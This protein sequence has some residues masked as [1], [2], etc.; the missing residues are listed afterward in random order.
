MKYLKSSI[1]FLV[2]LLSPV[3][4]LKSQD[5]WEQL[6]FPDSTAI[7][8]IAVND[9]GNIFVGA[10]NDGVSGGLYRSI[11][12]AQTW[13][14]VLDLGEFSVQS[15]AI[16]ENGY[17][18]IGRTG[19]Y[20]FMVS[21]DDGENWDALEL[22]SNGNVVSIQCIGIDTVFAGLAVSNGA[23]LLRSSD[24]GQS[25]DSV[26]TTIGHP[27]EYVSDIAVSSAGE[28]YISL[29]CFFSNMGGIYRSENG[30]DTWEYAGLINHQVYSVEFNSNDDLFIGVWSDFIYATGGLYTIYNGSDTVEELLF[31]PSVTEM[32]INS[33]DDI[34]F[35]DV[36]SGIIRSQDNGQTFEY[37]NEGLSGTIGRMS[38][39]NQGFIYLSSIY[40][41]NKLAKSIDPTITGIETEPLINYSYYFQVFPNPASDRLTIIFKENF[42]HKNEEII[43]F[44]TLGIEVKQVPVSQNVKE[45]V[46]DVSKLEA[47][48]YFTVMKV[49]GVEVATG[50]FLVVR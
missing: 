17:I 32:V 25:W 27:S 34:Y 9:Q 30:G 10:A 50:K 7:Y 18:Y 26:F 28:I 41:S 20:N 13:E 6:Y 12:T 42:N 29:M 4:S 37:V 45:I 5:F 15:I 19:F 24:H 31:G 43:I 47:G 39:D 38:I 2:I 40:S 35:A 16:N 1:L 33:D 14:L 11:D 8:C 23:L 22:P 21:Q 49:E 48:L 46:V 3:L 36:P 44:N